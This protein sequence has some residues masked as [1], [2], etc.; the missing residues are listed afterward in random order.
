MQGS[1]DRGAQPIREIRIAHANP[2]RRIQFTAGGNT[3]RTDTTERRTIAGD[4][5]NVNK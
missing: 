1:N 5:A 4:L 2:S 3:N